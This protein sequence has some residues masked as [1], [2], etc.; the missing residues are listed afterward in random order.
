MNFINAANIFSHFFYVTSRKSPVVR[1]ILSHHSGCQ[2]SKELL[3]GDC[4]GT[5]PKERVV[6]ILMAILC[7]GTN[8][9][10]W[11]RLQWEWKYQRI[12]LQETT[13]SPCNCPA[14]LERVLAFLRMNL[15]LG[16]KWFE[17]VTLWPFS[18]W[19][20]QA[21]FCCC[22]CFNS[23][24]MTKLARVFGRYGVP[25][26]KNLANRLQTNL[27]CRVGATQCER[28][29][30]CTPNAPFWHFASRSEIHAIVVRLLPQRYHERPWNPILSFASWPSPLAQSEFREL[31]SLSH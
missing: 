1:P 24:S 17:T 27:W 3:A 5:S 15:T 31:S 25:S 18:K 29:A 19:E 22:P 6:R 8:I 30:H 7:C 23:E 11:F 21:K 26:S 10:H 28:H 12:S 20:C 14:W 13:F 9:R 4:H 2:R 16:L